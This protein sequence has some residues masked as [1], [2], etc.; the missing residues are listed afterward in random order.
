MEK[1]EIVAMAI[2]AIA[3]ELKTEVHRVKVLSFHEVEKNILERY[4]EEN[5]IDY[6]KYQ[7]GD[8]V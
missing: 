4:I 2:A 3:E 7:L 1:E 6:N 8:L 5:S